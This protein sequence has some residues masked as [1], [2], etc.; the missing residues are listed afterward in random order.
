MPASWPCA[1]GSTADGVL[2]SRALD[3]IDELLV[4]GDPAMAK[5]ISAF[6][7]G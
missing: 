6:G 4:L 5:S 1:Y 2:R 7:E 3:V